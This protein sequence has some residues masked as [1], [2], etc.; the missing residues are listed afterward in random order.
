M[1]ALPSALLI[2]VQIP[3]VQTY[4]IHRA[5]GALSSHADAEINIGHVYYSFFNKLVIQDISIVSPTPLGNSDTLLACKTLSISIKPQSLLNRRFHADRLILEDG[6]FNFVTEGSGGKNNVSRI[7][8]KG[9]KKDKRNNDFVLSVDDLRLNDFRFGLV[10]KTSSR[11][12]QHGPEFIDFNDLDLSGIYVHLKG[13]RYVDNVLHAQI[14]NLSAMDKSGYFISRLTGNA[15]VSSHEARIS[16]LFI[17]D[18]YSTVRALYYSMKYESAKSFADYVHDVHMA[19]VFNNTTLDFRTIG[20]MSPGLENCSV[21]VNI[22]GHVSGPVDNMRGDN[23]YVTMLSGFTSLNLDASIKGLPDVDETISNI[24]IKESSFTSSDISEIIAGFGNGKSPEFLESLNPFDV[25]RFNGEIDGLLTDFALKGALESEYGLAEADV[26]INAA[27][28][29]KGFEIKGFA[30]LTDTDLRYFSGIGLLGNATAYAA[31]GATIKGKDIDLDLRRLN[32]GNIEIN[33]YGY[34]GITAEASYSGNIFDGVLEVSDPNLK[35]ALKGKGSSDLSSLDVAADLEHVNLS[36]I[37]I[38][39]RDSVSIASAALHANFVSNGKGDIF[40]NIEA[41]GMRYENEWKKYKF[42]DLHYNSV[43]HE[44]DY[45]I[46][47]ASP[48]LDA[49]YRGDAP[50]SSCIDDVKRKVIGEMLPAVVKGIEKGEFPSDSIDSVH[51]YEMKVVMKDMDN[52]LDAVFPSV[53]IADSS[54]V[55]FRVAGR[56]ADFRFASDSLGWGGA[57]LEGIDL[58]VEKDSVARIAMRWDGFSLW[59]MNIS[60]VLLESRIFNNALATELRFGGNDSDYGAGVFPGT[61]HDGISV[62]DG[63]YQGMYGIPAYASSARPDADIFINSKIVRDSSGGIGFYSS[64]DSSYVYFKSARWDILPSSVDY[65][66]GRLVFDGFSILNGSQ[67]FGI[68]GSLSKDD[69]DRLSLAMNRFDISILNLLMKKNMDL[70]G[71][72]T[73]GAD[74]GKIGGETRLLL[75]VKGDSLSISGSEIGGLDLT[76]RWNSDYSRL[77]V[78]MSNVLDGRR[79]FYAEGFYAPST[80]SI[81]FDLEADSLPVKYFEPVLSSVVTDLGGSVSFSGAKISGTLQSPVADCPAV[82]FNGMNLTI[83]YT[84]VPYVLDG[85]ASVNSSG[86]SF[87]NAVITDSGGGRGILNGGLEYEFFKD[88]RVNLNLLFDNL[89]CLNT[90]ETDN[91]A[92]YGNVTG[93]GALDMTGPFNELVLDMNFSTGPNSSFHIPLSSSS[94]ASNTDIIKFVNPFASDDVVEK[95]RAMEDKPNIIV[96]M[97]AAVNPDADI[98]IEI[99]KSL[100]D[101]LRTTG[102]GNVSLEVNPR[103][104]L[105]N[106]FGDYTVSDGSYR[107]VIL[108]I[109]SKDFELQE[110][111]Q[112]NFNGNIMNSTLNLAA[113]YRTKASLNTLISDTTSIST[114]RTV[115]CNIQMSGALVNP[116]LRFSIDIPDL[117]PTTKARVES[118][119]SSDDKVQKQFASLLVSGNF[120]PDE[121]SNIVDNSSLL[122]SNAS[123]MISNQLNNVFRQ[124]DIPLDLGFNYQPGAERGQDLFDVAI[125]TQLFNNRVVVN[126]N[127]GNGQYDKANS[128]VGDIDIEIKIE[129][130]GRLRLNLFSHSADQ[131]SNYLDDSQRQ[132]IGIVYQEEFNTFDELYR[133]IFWSK[134]RQEAYRRKMAREILESGK[135]SGNA[136]GQE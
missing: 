82:R 103:N 73:G 102:T 55:D 44:G 22:T 75:D 60:D 112:I 91:S 33:G 47:I 12:R 84:K 14:R 90:A 107:F 124:L 115:D 83:D 11:Y 30:G 135:S 45:S 17:K 96:R 70:Q 81:G 68:D 58:S 54:I 27:E 62:P 94:N 16:N 36:A 52:V 99:N 125:S 50:L 31:F 85:Y 49:D 127:I 18:N 21:A 80:K 4:L 113:S 10:N 86:A 116:E 37:N 134:K 1:I 76:S 120:V 131:Y 88:F 6:V 71:F 122:Y 100:G 19:A 118:A 63:F 98:Q 51:S 39:R 114:R 13:L 67:S 109:T 32:V 89:Q 129:K 53:R 92:F 40:G 26:V 128:V 65:H 111:G 57:A 72:L 56:N 104:D 93:S 8:G 117:E 69:A 61:A 133:R 105:F 48:F 121:Q 29:E 9:K 132:G 95:A 64:F 136:N 123:E 130:K 20:K 35:L 3:S 77:D 41:S 24:K 7:F 38:N 42:G 78:M 110:G 25:Y 79:Q 126:G 101:I 108:G 87:K 43:S 97:N 15:E 106:I 66:G 59:K 23:L 46:H 5:V 34:T 119:L 28:P 2:T 74:L